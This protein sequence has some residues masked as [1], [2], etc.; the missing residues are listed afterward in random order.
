MGYLEHVE[1][2]LS[3]AFPEAQVHVMRHGVCGDTVFDG[4]RRLPPLL[5]RLRPNVVLVQ[6]GLND[7]FQGIP[8]RRFAGGLDA[9]LEQC[10]EAG[11]AG[12]V[13]VPP[14]PPRDPLWEADVQPFR[15]VFAECGARW[16]IP[17][18]P[19]AEHWRDA[20]PDEVLWLDDGVHPSEA[21]YR[22]MAAAVLQALRAE[23][24]P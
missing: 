19:V 15:A 17:I 5:A 2:G 1:A 4:L 16:K 14:P 11:V 9:V 6:F 8:P 24:G 21:G 3:T 7:L 13:L 12:A 22:H 18:A 20:A 23:E 10:A